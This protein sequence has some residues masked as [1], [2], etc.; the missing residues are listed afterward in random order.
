VLLAD[1]NAFIYA[2][3][4][5]S[6]RAPEHRAWL[7]EALRGPEPFGVSE[8]V[9]ASFL[10]IVTNH[11][12]YREPTPPRIALDFCAAVL[13]APSAV[14]VRP[15]PRHWRLF[16]DLCDT[17]G[18][19]GNTVP[20]AYLAALALEHGATWVTTDRGFGRFPG[21]RWRVPLGEV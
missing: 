5:E 8:L 7:T 3:R 12:V 15:G 16:N 10:R 17:V 6:P 20:D 21:L 19:R 9:L 2:H 18:A 4:P 1:V 14:A 13:G 11:R